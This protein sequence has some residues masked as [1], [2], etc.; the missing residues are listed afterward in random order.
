MFGCVCFVHD[1]SP[2][3]D[4]LS[5]HVKCVFLGYSQLQTRYYCYSPKSKKYYMYV[6][7]TFEHTLF[8]SLFVQ[9]VSSIQEVLP[10]P[11]VESS[12]PHA[13]DNPKPVQN[14]PPEPSSFLLITYQCKTQMAS[15][16]LQG[17]SSS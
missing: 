6:S 14:P 12:I 13:P 10:M 4:K 2:G 7:V 8:F 16:M 17:E 1:L 15:P 3:L 9:D 5:A 11:F